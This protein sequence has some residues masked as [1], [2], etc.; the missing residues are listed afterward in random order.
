MMIWLHLTA[1]TLALGLGIANLALAKGTRRHRIVGWTWLVTMSFVTLSSF[2]IRELNEGAF[3]WIH[4]LTVWTLFCM[5]VAIIAIRRG[6]VRTHASFMIGTM[7]G[8]IVAG[9]F[10]LAP[11]RFISSL[12]GA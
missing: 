5:A 10:A 9:L 1:A 8:V 7:V 4:G 2:P 11:G 3:S 12:L 6:W